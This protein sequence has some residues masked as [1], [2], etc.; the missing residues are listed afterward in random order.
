MTHLWVR[1]ETRENEERVGLTPEGAAKLRAKGM[2]IT[3]EKS[4]QRRIPITGYVD[5]GCDIAP[6]GAWTA[7]PDNAIVFGLKE[8]PDNGTPL[9][10]RHIMFGHAFKGQPAGRIL[11]DRFKAGAGTLLDLEYL[12][13]PKGVRVAAFGYWAGYAGAAVALHC[14][15]AQ[16]AGVD[17][18]ALS[19]Y[20][21]SK[22]MCAEI[23]DGSGD[24]R[25]TALIIGA[26]GRVGSGA[27]DFCAAVGIVTT[28]WDMAETASGGPFPEVLAHDIFL[29]CILARPGTPV[30]VPADAVTL[31]RKLTVIGDIAC[32]PDSDFSP[33][34]VYDCATTWA[35]PALRVH[36]DPPL[37]VTAIDN[38]P[39][40]MPLESSEDFAN[41]LLPHL[42]ALSSDSE[43][44]WGRAK[45]RFQQHV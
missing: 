7:A 32:D 10:H 27:R 20:A 39:S 18:P 13:D 38:L 22:A 29:N 41:Q 15:K 37:D 26:L 9:H 23:Q 14:W 43:G 21:S 1:A 19:T 6:Q 40:L 33:I 2:K 36:D 8:L 44:V 28:D 11:L 42:A 4:D 5:A 25:P 30:F 35:Q 31:P 16:Q 3:I 12:T 34:K 17:A 45:D 24:V